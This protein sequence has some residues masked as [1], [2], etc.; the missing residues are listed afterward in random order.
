[1]EYPMKNKNFL[2]TQSAIALL[3]LLGLNLVS[4]P[5]ACAEGVQS[6]ANESMDAQLRLQK[7]QEEQPQAQREKAVDWQDWDAKFQMTYVWQQKRPFSAPYTGPNS[8]STAKEKSYTFSATAYL[9]A[10]LWAGSEVYLDPEVVQGVPYSNLNGLGGPTN[11]E[12]QKVTGAN[13][14]FYIPR[15]FV[16]QTWGF[17]GGSETVDSQFNQLSGFV[18]KRRLVLTVGKLG[19]V[20]LFDSNSFNHDPRTQFLNW[21]AIDYGPFDFAADARGFS[22]GVTLEY[23]HDDWVVR[24]GRYMVP[25]DSNGLQLNYSIMKYH[26]DQLELEHRHEIGGQP[27]RLRFLYFRNVARMGGFQDALNYAAVNGGTPDV[28]NVRHSN[29]KHGY[30]LSLEQN[31]TS[32]L[33]LFARTSWADGETETYSYTEVERSQQLGVAL[34]GT[35]WGREQDSVGAAFIRNGLSGVHQAYLAAGGLGFFIG[36]GRLNYRPEQIFETYYSIN[37]YKKSWLTLDYQQIMNP[38][39]NA[40]RHG[41]VRVPGIRIHAEF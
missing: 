35:A 33:G 27:G 30:G 21:A 12:L 17:G 28:G 3:S 7:G 8:L 10:R 39:Y 22:I 6:S 37:V 41:P 26:G 32:D 16:R 29:V 4:P 25:R 2:W 19:I 36:D 13:P 23:Y 38:A 24:G 14:T 15:V 5:V 20:D 34:K 9:G 31:L 18:D 40:D 11:G 1:M